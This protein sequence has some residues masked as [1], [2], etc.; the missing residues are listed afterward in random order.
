MT[1][2][3]AYTIQAIADELGK[4]TSYVDQLIRDKYLVA[5]K[6]GRTTIVL[7]ADFEAFL[8]Q[9]PYAD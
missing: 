3:R 8:E 6:V 5:R 2:R 1:L 4:S 9:L 7:A